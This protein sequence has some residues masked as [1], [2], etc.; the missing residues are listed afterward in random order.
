MGHR[1]CNY[2]MT[3]RQSDSAHAARGGAPVLLIWS[4]VAILAG[5][6]LLSYWFCKFCNKLESGAAKSEEP[7]CNN[8]IIRTF[9]LVSFGWISVMFQIFK[10]ARCSDQN[11]HYV[12]FTFDN[13]HSFI[14]VHYTNAAT[15]NDWWLFPSVKLF[16]FIFYYFVALQRR[17]V[18]SMFTS[19]KPLYLA[20]VS[21]ECSNWHN[22]E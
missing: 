14:I 8:V 20:N 22:T 10:V 12:N 15:T 16:I 11:L 17:P 3:K 13:L 6:W 21:F 19:E 1:V 4:R 2:I 18:C 9:A 5:H 7:R